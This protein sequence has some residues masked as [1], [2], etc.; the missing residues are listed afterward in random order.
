MKGKKIE[1]KLQKNKAMGNPVYKNTASV[2]MSKY[3]SSLVQNK[4]NSIS[5]SRITIK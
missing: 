1:H 4:W 3:L 2:A 5:S